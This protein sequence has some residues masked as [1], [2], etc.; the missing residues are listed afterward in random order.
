[1]ADLNIRTPEGNGYYDEMGYD[2]DETLS[3]KL[4]IND[5]GR[6][7]KH[8]IIKM[9]KTKQV[10]HFLDKRLEKERIVAYYP[11]GKPYFTRRTHPA[12]M[13]LLQII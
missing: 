2:T 10:R 1:M 9:V 7:L 8:C 4:E 13:C 3:R 11:N 6:G 5:V 12:T